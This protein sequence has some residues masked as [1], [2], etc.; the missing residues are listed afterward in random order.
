M[1][2]F[3]FVNPSPNVLGELLQVST[4]RLPEGT[5]TGTTEASTLLQQASSTLRSSAHT[6]ACY[7][8]HFTHV[9][10]FMPL[11]IQVFPAPISAVT[12]EAVENQ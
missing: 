12:K 6:L 9:F 4:P 11:L 5:T 3:S 7:L 1:H 8:L 10:Y 2:D